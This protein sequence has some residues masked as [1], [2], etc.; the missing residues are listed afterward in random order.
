MELHRFPL[1]IQQLT[2]LICSKF[3]S[4]KYKLVKNLNKISEI[5]SQALSTFRDQ[6]KWISFT[7]ENN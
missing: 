1:D 6:Q 4:D 7:F 3:T 2:I 5:E